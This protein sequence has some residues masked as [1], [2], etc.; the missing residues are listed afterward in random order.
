MS[1]NDFLAVNKYNPSEKE[2]ETAREKLSEYERMV[3]GG[4]GSLTTEIVVEYAAIIHGVLGE[5]YGSIHIPI[6]S[7]ILAGKGYF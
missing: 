5:N 1:W 4:D 3:G 7:M 6:E 2:L